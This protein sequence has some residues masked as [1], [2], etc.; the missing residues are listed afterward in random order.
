M[1]AA[2]TITQAAAAEPSC[3][4]WH[5]P[6]W[7]LYLCPPPWCLPAKGRS[8]WSCFWQPPDAAVPLVVAT[9]LRSTAAELAQPFT[10]SGRGAAAVGAA[11]LMLSR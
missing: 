1:P 2:A 8:L 11:K 5:P 7:C 3:Y 9:Q 4:P 6:M 10:V